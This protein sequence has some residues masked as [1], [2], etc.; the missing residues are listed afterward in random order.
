MFPVYYDSS[1]LDIVFYCLQPSLVLLLSSGLAHAIM[2]NMK[3][4]YAR[5]VKSFFVRSG[6][7]FGFSVSSML[8]PLLIKKTLLESW[9]YY[10]PWIFG[11]IIVVES[12]FNIPG[13]GFSLWQAFRQRDI[14]QVFY[15]LFLLG[16]CYAAFA[17][18]FYANQKKLSRLLQSYS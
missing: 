11:E 5:W 16:S 7:G 12:I 10:F 18:I 9:I 6:Q 1:V 15:L 17:I 4:N 3:I 14:D 2:T 13:I 8:K